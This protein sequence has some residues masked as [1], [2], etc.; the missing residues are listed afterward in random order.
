MAGNGISAEQVV[1]AIKD[2]K[3]LISVIAGRLG[4][5]ERH[6]YNLLD[7]YATAKEARDNEREKLKDFVES[8]MLKKIEAGDT[9][10][11]IFYAKTQMK[12]RGYVERVEN[13]GKDGGAIN[14]NL[15]W[16]TPGAIDPDDGDA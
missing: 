16:P 6:V 9:A 11:I 8:R 7:K 4:V 2:S 10:M 15:N 14:V 12:D 13:T 1:E 5:T 3:G